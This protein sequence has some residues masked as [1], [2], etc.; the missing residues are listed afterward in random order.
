M[1]DGVASASAEGGL[2]GLPV[3]TDASLE[4]LQGEVVLDVIAAIVRHIG[5]CFHVHIVDVLGGQNHGG[6]ALASDD[7]FGLRSW[8]V[9]GVLEHALLLPISGGLANAVFWVGK[10]IQITLEWEMGNTH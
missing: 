7:Q 5:G 6:G 4:G 3:E 9:R 8:I 10:V 1:A 2:E